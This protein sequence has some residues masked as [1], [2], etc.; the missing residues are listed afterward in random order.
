MALRDE[1]K[2]SYTGFA[3]DSGIQYFISKYREEIEEK[4]FSPNRLPTRKGT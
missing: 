3:G 1:V 4:C 2:I